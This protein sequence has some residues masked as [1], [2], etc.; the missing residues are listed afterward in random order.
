MASSAE[1][2]IPATQPPQGT[3][4]ATSPGPALST[5]D[6]IVVASQPST[7]L[8]APRGGRGSRGGVQGTGQS[9]TVARGSRGGRGGRTQGGQTTGRQ[10]GLAPSIR[11]T[12]SQWEGVSLEAGG[13]RTTGTSNSQNSGDIAPGPSSCARTKRTAATQSP[14]VARGSKRT[15]GTP[16]SGAQV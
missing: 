5:Q 15:R 1:D 7:A 3:P 6:T 16:D 2:V 13:S 8:R 9:A 12:P 11:R 10:S 14:R 4:V